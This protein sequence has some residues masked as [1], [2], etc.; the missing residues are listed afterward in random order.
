M[1]KNL[2]NLVTLVKNDMSFIQM[3]WLLWAQQGNLLII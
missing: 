2:L 1:K 3:N